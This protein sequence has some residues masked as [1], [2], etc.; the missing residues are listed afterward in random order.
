MD[1]TDLQDE[2]L[3]DELERLHSA[4]F[5]WALWCCDHRREDAEEVL[6]TAYLKVLEGTAR[7]NGRSSLRT[8]FFAVVRRTAWEQRRRR[9]VRELLLARWWRQPALAPCGEPDEA[10]RSS[11]ESHAL[12]HAL[13]ALPTRQR[14][15][16][17]LVFY[18]ELTI[19]EAAKVLSI[20]LGAARTHFERGKARLRTLLEQE[21]KR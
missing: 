18:Q 2:L 4:S 5:G 21:A 7:F 3:R 16:L 19:E 17:H 12:R 6:Q 1:Q 15:V 10:L 14:E 20:S 13:A 9:W 8:W 11:E